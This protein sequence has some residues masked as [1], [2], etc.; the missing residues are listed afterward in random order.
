MSKP[1]CVGFVSPSTGDRRLSFARQGALTSWSDPLTPSS[2][3][4]ATVL[5]AG[6]ADDNYGAFAAAVGRI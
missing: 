5:Y 2:K 3:L 6:Y 4:G 1:S